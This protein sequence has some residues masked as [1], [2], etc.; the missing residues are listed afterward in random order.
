MMLGKT[1][2]ELERVKNEAESMREEV[3]S[4]ARLLCVLYEEITYDLA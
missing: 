1:Q 4:L 3:S 2:R